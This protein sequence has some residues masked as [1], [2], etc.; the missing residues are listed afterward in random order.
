MEFRGK[1]Q[2]DFLCKVTGLNVNDLTREI[3]IALLKV[4]GL[5]CPE[6]KTYEDFWEDEYKGVSVF[7]WSV[8]G[9]VIKV[10][11][12]IAHKFSVSVHV[13]KEFTACVGSLI[14][15]GDGDCPNCGA[16]EYEV[17]GRKGLDIGGYDVPHDF[18]GTIYCKCNNCN[19]DF[20][21]NR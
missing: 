21:L 7:D 6:K 18:V 14:M 4:D 10:C 3:E 17:T 20:N 5:I 19:V 11:S 16:K 2:I 1:E 15:M 9:G 8:D 13:L 12:E